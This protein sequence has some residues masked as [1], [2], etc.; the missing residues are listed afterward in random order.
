MHRAL[1][2]SHLSRHLA[3]SGQFERPGR[4]DTRKN[5]IESAA[6]GGSGEARPARAG[7]PRASPHACRS[8]QSRCRC[9]VYGLAALSPELTLLPPM[10]EANAHEDEKE[11]CHLRPLPIGRTDIALEDRIGEGK[12]Q[13]KDEDGERCGAEALPEGQPEPS[14]EGR[15]EGVPG[16]SLRQGQELPEIRDRPREWGEQKVRRAQ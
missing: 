8:G 16:Q 13:G 2:Q 1:F 10:L 12:D 6:L 9:P 7:Q 4:C 5:A 14:G 3:G 11:H 15:H